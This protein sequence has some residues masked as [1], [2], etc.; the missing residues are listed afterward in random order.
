MVD[1]SET[2]LLDIS[3]QYNYN[4]KLYPNYST[5]QMGFK[6]DFCSNL[7]QYVIFDKMQSPSFSGLGLFVLQDPK[8]SP[9]RNMDVTLLQV[10]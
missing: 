2:R 9:V 8:K 7:G 4:V 3:S 1:L 6:Q 5:K 10:L